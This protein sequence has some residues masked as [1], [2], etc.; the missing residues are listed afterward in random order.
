MYK[1]YHQL[2]NTTLFRYLMLQHVSNLAADQFQG[3]RQFPKNGNPSNEAAADLRLR[4][5]ATD[6]SSVIRTYLIHDM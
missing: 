3:A 1:I 6:F 2:V 5:H 4:L